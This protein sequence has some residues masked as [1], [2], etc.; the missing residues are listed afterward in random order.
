MLTAN[1]MLEKAF[2]MPRSYIKSKSDIPEGKRA[3]KCALQRIADAP[4]N[5]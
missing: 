2:P 5:A 4:H 1:Q 3:A